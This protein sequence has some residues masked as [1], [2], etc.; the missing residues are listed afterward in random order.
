MFCFLS[1]RPEGKLRQLFPEYLKG[2]LPEYLGLPSWQAAQDPDVQVFAMGVLFKTRSGPLLPTP[3]CSDVTV[4]VSTSHSFRNHV[5][6][7]A[8]FLKC[9]A[10]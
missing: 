10:V 9:T 5:A 8:F 6:E 3:S 2:V 7:V 1:I 4:V